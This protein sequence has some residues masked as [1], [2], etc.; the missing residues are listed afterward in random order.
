MIVCIHAFWS[1]QEST[2]DLR[3]ANTWGDRPNDLSGD[4]V[5]YFEQVPPFGI[6]ILGPDDSSVICAGKFCMN[7]QESRAAPHATRQNIANAQ[8]VA[9]MANIGALLTITQGRVPRD[10]Q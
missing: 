10:D 7:S 8:I 2:L 9:D 4:V 3:S 1:L 6:E 5:L